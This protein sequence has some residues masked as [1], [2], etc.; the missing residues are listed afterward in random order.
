MAITF[1]NKAA[2]EMRQRVNNLVG[3]GADS[4]W[5]ATFHSTCV[6]ILRRYIGHLGFDTTFS[7]YDTD[8]Q[9]TVMKDVCKRLNIDTKVYKERYLMSVISRAKDELVSPMEMAIAAAPAPLT[10]TLISSRFLCTTF[11]AFISPASVMTA[12]PCWSS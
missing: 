4:V 10:T 6:R 11:S 8:D 7:I 2:G 9:K 1:T 3:Q 5:V 12:V